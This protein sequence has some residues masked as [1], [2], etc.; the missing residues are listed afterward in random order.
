M[1]IHNFK[2][3]ECPWAWLKEPKTMANHVIEYIHHWIK[4]TTVIDSLEH[5]PYRSAIVYVHDSNQKTRNL[6]T[7]IRHTT[8]PVI[9]SDFKREIHNKYLMALRFRMEF[10]GSESLSLNRTHADNHVIYRVNDLLLQFND[11][12]MS[13]GT[14]VHIESY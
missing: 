1:A 11:S 5:Y 10:K 14:D 7:D 6:Q 3:P 2:N 4:P 12:R 8:D 9:I 13:F